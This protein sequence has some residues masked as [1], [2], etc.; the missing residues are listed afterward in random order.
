MRLCEDEVP[1][2]SD[3]IWLCAN[4]ESKSRASLNGD[5]SGFARRTS[6][7]VEHV[8]A[9]GKLG[10]TNT[11]GIRGFILEK[12]TSPGEHGWPAYF[13]RYSISSRILRK[14]KSPT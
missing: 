1:D 13:G 5:R 11:R 10:T 9:P 8:S 7:S 14:P 4:E 6:N 12:S 3:K 2:V